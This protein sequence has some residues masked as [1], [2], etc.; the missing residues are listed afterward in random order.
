MPS[1]TFQMRPALFVSEAPAT[2]RKRFSIALRPG[3]LVQLP[4]NV[5]GLS[6]IVL[7]GEQ[8]S[9]YLALVKRNTG[10]AFFQHEARSTGLFCPL[11]ACRRLQRRT[12]G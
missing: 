4:Q 6:A 7:E 2:H 11:A 8:L 3:S 10:D 9:E 5:T 12:I 1:L